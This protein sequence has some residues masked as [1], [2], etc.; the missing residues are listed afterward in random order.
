M[1][2]A[3]RPHKMF[4]FRIVCR[5]RHTQREQAPKDRLRRIE[6]AACDL[7]TK[8]HDLLPPAS[9]IAVHRKERLLTEPGVEFT[10]RRMQD[11]RFMG[12]NVEP[13]CT[14]GF[15]R[16]FAIGLQHQSANALGQ[17]GCGEYPCDLS[18]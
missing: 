8:P 18:Y 11:G 6:K 4:A 3:K 14:K 10:E 17:H 1:G 5:W 2:F 7:Q 13:I 16:E 12:C 9:R 15:S